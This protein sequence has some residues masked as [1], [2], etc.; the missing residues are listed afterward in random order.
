MFK[1][2]FTVSSLTRSVE[3]QFIHNKQN[4]KTIIR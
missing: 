4:K 1:A 3:N 2:K